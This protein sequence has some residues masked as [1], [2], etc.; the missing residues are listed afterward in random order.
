MA[1]KS[2]EI[3]TD[4]DGRPVDFICPVSV[5]ICRTDDDYL[6][7]PDVLDALY[8]MAEYFLLYEFNP[9]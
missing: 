8:W 2:Y 7:D 6:A 1:K 9:N 3:H 5:L 4:E